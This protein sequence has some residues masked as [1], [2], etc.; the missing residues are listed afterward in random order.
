MCDYADLISKVRDM[1]LR[2]L[3]ASINHADDEDGDMVLICEG[4]LS[5]LTDVLELL[6]SE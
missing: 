5:A 6:E 3:A 4:R 1:R 2:A